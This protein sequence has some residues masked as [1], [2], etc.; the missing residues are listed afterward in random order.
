MHKKNTEPLIKTGAD[1]LVDLVKKSK[2]IPLSKT[3]EELGVSEKVVE[4]WAYYLETEEKILH[5]ATKGSEKYLVIG[6]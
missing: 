3:A 6:K 4:D 1:L 2:K 5:I